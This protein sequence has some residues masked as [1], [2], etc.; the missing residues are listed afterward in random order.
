MFSL[1]TKRRGSDSCR[2]Q[3]MASADGKCVPSPR[4]HVH[5]PVATAVAAVGRSEREECP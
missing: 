1:K 5:R 2:W 3:P 4:L